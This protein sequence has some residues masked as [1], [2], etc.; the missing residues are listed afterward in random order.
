MM[1]LFYTGLR[2]IYQTENEMTSYLL[3]KKQISSLESLTRGTALLAFS[4]LIFTFLS[5]QLKWSNLI[6]VGINAK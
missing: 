5:Q 6:P 3:L 1:S 2:I 4:A